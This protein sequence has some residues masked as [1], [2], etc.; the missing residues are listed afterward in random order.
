MDFKVSDKNEKTLRIL[1]YFKKD[2]IRKAICF[3]FYYFTTDPET[4]GTFFFFL[5]FF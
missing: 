5:F 3:V 1:L 4:V 2:H